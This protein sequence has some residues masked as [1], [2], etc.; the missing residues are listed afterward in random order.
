MPITFIDIERRKS[1]KI[2][3]FF[4]LLV[5]LYFV[6]TP[7]LFISFCEIFSL[8]P[9]YNGSLLNANHILIIFS[10]AVITA[11]IHF[12]FSTVNAVSFIKSNLSA[13]NPDPQDRIHKRLTNIVDEIHT[14][15]G[16][17]VN[18]KCLV[19]PTLSM[20]ALSAVD[21]KGNAIIVVTE[22]L[23]SRISR[24]QLEAVVAHEAYHI[25][26]GD[27]LESTVAASLFG[28]PSSVIEKIRPAIGGRLFFSP[29]FLFAWLMVKL[30]Y[31]LNM[32]ISREREYRADAGAV[33]MT[34]NPLA[35]AE[36]LNLL[37]RNWRGTGHIGTGLE[38]LCFMNP[39]SCA[40]DE[41]DGWFANLLSTHPPVRKR[42]NILLNMARAGI[43]ELNKNTKA[44][45]GEGIRKDTVSLFYALDN[46]HQWQGPYTLVELAAIP[47]F[48]TLTW[49]S[50]DGGDV[51]KASQIPI[52]DAIFKDRL[53][54][55]EKAVSS[56][57]CPS[58]RH[59][60]IKKSYEDTIIYQCKFCGGALVEDNK[61]PRIIA[62]T[63][64]EST[65]RIKALSRVTL[66]KNQMKRIA[67]NKKKND[68]AVM[69]HIPCPKCGANMMRTFYSQAYLIE[70]DRCT[71]CNITWFDYDEL[72]M[73]QCM[74]DNKMASTPLPI[75]PQY[76]NETI[77]DI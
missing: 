73:L 44:F 19:I 59:P 57:M 36:V 47:W 54:R 32:F 51:E 75:S 33:R 46:M 74:I 28:I 34:R 39:S 17:R 49:V 72:E 76:N 25:L 43:S 69:P 77:P 38:M 14:A 20:N 1:W 4:L 48:T 16:N 37:S 60:L 35:L 56:Y 2:G 7:A 45:A 31:L 66:R 5:L 27:C 40:L 41:S 55:E 71:F 52:I 11:T 61:L 24:T 21:F 29:A 68:E 58:C 13:L 42:I 62:R 3:I 15:S 9:I 18:I 63:D 64:T 53:A 70:L 26:S 8:G 22:G 12:Y 65:D 23:L 10:F 6:I 30:S 50:N 67:R